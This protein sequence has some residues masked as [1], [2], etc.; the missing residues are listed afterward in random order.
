MPINKDFFKLHFF[1]VLFILFYDFTKKSASHV[2]V[3][4]RGQKVNINSVKKMVSLVPAIITEPQIR[5]EHPHAGL[6]H[7]DDTITDGPNQCHI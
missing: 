3:H 6:S 7:E 1:L 2:H 5:C 4:N